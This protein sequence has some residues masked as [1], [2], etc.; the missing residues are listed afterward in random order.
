MT[1]LNIQHTASITKSDFTK[2]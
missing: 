2:N 1:A